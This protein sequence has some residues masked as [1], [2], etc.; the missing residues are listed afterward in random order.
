[1]CIVC[2]N[3]DYKLYDFTEITLFIS[4]NEYLYNT[5]YNTHRF[6]KMA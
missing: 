5:N 4:H 2:E 1:M 6:C 3:N